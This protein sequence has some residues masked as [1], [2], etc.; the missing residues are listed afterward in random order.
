MKLYVS[1]FNN[2]EITR[3]ERYTRGE[4]GAE[5]SVKRGQ[6]I[7]SA[8]LTR[9]GKFAAKLNSLLD[10]TCSRCSGSRRAAVARPEARLMWASPDPSTPGVL[11]QWGAQETAPTAE[12][13]SGLCATNG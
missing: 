7:G 5:G 4:Q 1:L 11:D 8:T 2:S 3:I 12:A 9:H 13:V 10:I 6:P